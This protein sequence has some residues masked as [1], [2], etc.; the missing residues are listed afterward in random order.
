MATDDM[1]QPRVL[2]VDDEKMIVRSLSRLLRMRGLD[3]VTAAGSTEA[4]ALLSQQEIALVLTDYNMPDMNGLDLMIEIRMRYP[5]TVRIMLTAFSEQ[6]LM[7]NAINRGE[8]YRFFSKP[9]NEDE[10]MSAITSGLVRNRSVRG[11]KKHLLKQREAIVTAKQQMLLEK[12]RFMEER[13]QILDALNR[14]NIETVTA[15]AEA[16]E[17]KDSYTRGHCTRVRNYAFRIARKID[18]SPELLTDLSYG[19]LLHDCGKIGISEE[20]LLKPGQLDP[21]QRQRIEEHPVKGY[22]LTRSVHHLQTASI[23]IRQHHEQWNGRGYPD[24][25][26][27][28]DIH[29]C[30]RMIAIADM[31]DAM[32]SDRP[33]RKGMAVSKAREILLNSKSKQLD[34]QLVDIFITLLDQYGIQEMGKDPLPAQMIQ[35]GCSG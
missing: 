1:T 2:I 4:L 26:K 11:E 12:E 23:F 3:V 33:Y 34:P 10:L 35:S 30:A 9:W 20:I 7:Q 32:T 27:G 15:I 22:H 19:A 13:E 14:S 16:I 17:L 25:L 21:F 6:H 5:D 24:G 18:L 31:F 29:I 8:I 28:E